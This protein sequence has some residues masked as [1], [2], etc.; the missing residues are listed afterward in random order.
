[1]ITGDHPLTAHA[2]AKGIGLVPANSGPGQAAA[3][4][5]VMLGQVLEASDEEELRQLV[6]R[7]SVYARVPPEQKLRIVRAL[8]ANGQVVAMTAT[9]MPASSRKKMRLPMEPR[10]SFMLVG[11]HLPR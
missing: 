3:A 8:Q 5:E 2:I 1:M 4:D 7:C 11:L 9:T 6:R 10:K